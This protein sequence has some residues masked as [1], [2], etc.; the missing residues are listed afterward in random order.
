MTFFNQCYGTKIVYLTYSQF[1]SKINN[2]KIKNYQKP[3]NDHNSVF[4]H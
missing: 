3:Y 1:F 4:Y 2:K